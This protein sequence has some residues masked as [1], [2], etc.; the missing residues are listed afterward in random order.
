MTAPIYLTG[1]RYVDPLRL[2]YFA[3]DHLHQVMVN[4]SYYC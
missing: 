4:V 2:Y 3:A 1:T